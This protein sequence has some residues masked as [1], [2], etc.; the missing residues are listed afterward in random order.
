MRCLIDGRFMHRLTSTG[1]WWTCTCGELRC[2]DPAVE[3]GWQIMAGRK[4]VSR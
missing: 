3:F 1:R 4:L 2:S